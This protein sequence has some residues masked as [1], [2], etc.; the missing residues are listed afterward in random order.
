MSV[1]ESKWEIS[2][3]LEVHIQL[4]TRTK[5]FSRAS[6]KA[7]RASPNRNASL[8]D[9]AYPG[10]LPVLNHTA[11]THA[12]RFGVAIGAPIARVCSFERKNYFYPDLPKGYQISQ[13]SQPIVGSGVF[14]LWLEDGQTK[15]IKIRRGHLE[16]DAGKSIHDRVP[17]AT[18]LD[19]NRAGA[20]LLEIVTA[21]DL[22]TPME[23]VACFRQLHA[24]AIWLDL[25][26]GKLNEGAMR[27]DANVSLRLAGQDNLGTPTELK[28]LNSFK[29]L[30]KALRYEID[31]H[32]MALSAGQ[33]VQRETR[34]YDPVSG[35][36]QSMRLKEQEEGYRYFI[37]P[38][39]PP[40]PISEE[41]I[42]RIA[43]STPELPSKMRERFI[44][45][46]GLAPDIAFR[47]TLEKPLAELFEATA[48]QCGDTS[49][50]ANW[51]LGELTALRKLKHS[52][53]QEIPISAKQLAKLILRVEDGT[54]SSKT[55]KELLRELWDTEIDLDH[56][57]QTRALTQISDSSQISM[58]VA[59]VI[60]ENRHL[61]PKVLQGDEKLIEYLIGQVMKISRGKANPHQVRESLDHEVVA[62]SKHLSA[63]N[64]N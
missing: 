48:V 39:L 18:V 2:I 11:V 21:P 55:G 60:E 53:A 37:D 45:E 20:P 63:E 46:F 61:I 12:V 17:N 41:F 47:L 13:F 49:A 15:P 54:I 22:N 5:L 9:L 4:K 36:T 50:T 8:V 62:Q 7:P 19:F 64:S 35:T 30:E 27:C 33:K 14:D 32:T 40:I 38:D 29:F 25:S 58:W 1:T 24:L 59:K 52:R 16:E 23:A 10:T 57:I 31:R 26:T 34:L 6:N 28:N 42:A 44:R 43:Q 3:G 51:I 56:F